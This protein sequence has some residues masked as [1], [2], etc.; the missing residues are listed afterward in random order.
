MEFMRDFPDDEACLQY[1]WRSHCAV[2]AEGKKAFCPK[3]ELDRPFHRVSGRP[4]WDCDYCGHHMHPTAGT[5]FHKSSTSLHLWFYAAYM[6]SKTR[7]GISAKQIERELGVTYKTA[8]RMLNKIR[9]QLMGPDENEPP[10][11]G[12]VEVDE[13]AYGGKPRAYDT[14]GMTRSEAISWAKSRK[15]TVLGM[16]ERRGRIRAAVQSER[17]PKVVQTVQRYVLPSSMVFTDDWAGYAR[18]GESHP[19]HRRVRHS[20]N[21]YV[22]GEVHTNT[23]EG[24]FGNL[25]TSLSGTYHAVSSRWLQSYLDEFTF[26]Y[27]HRDDPTPMFQI[28][29]GR[30]AS[31]ARA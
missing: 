13:T 29:L 11:S 7:C 24:F 27:N 26:R 30:I 16:V 23:I 2:D 4:A 17:S 18:L 25:K 1:L 9:S 14:K 5:I 28:I 6:V 8:W 21:I 19:R 15:T 31:G 3:C 22:D 20:E 12:E 10:L